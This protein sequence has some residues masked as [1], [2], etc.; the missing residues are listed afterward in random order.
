MKDLER[1]TGIHDALRKFVSRGIT[2]EQKD[3]MAIAEKVRAWLET[4]KDIRHGDW[5]MADVEFLN[6][7]QVGSHDRTIDLMVDHMMR[8]ALGPLARGRGGEGLKRTT[9]NGLLLGGTRRPCCQQGL[10]TSCRR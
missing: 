10:L 2:K 5:T 8:L 1:V 9:G 3:E 7:N 6:A 4:G